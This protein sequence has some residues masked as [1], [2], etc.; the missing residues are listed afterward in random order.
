MKMHLG[1]ESLTSL[2]VGKCVYDRGNTQSKKGPKFNS[3]VVNL[4]QAYLSLYRLPHHEIAV[5]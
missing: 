3:G 5:A 4:I 2:G 1:L